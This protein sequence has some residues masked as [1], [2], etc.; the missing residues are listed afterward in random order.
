MNVLV[1]LE[2]GNKIE[3]EVEVEFGSIRER[4][5]EFIYFD[6][7]GLHGAIRNRME[8]ILSALHLLS[9]H[10]QFWLTYDVVLVTRRD[11]WFPRSTSEPASHMTR[12]RSAWSATSSVAHKPMKALLN[13]SLSFITSRNCISVVKGKFT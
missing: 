3:V 4:M 6:S 2:S 13:E 1:L 10:T 12:I 11:R 7:L 9:H 8:V 5:G